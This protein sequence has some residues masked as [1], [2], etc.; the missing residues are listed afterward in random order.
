MENVN[1]CGAKEINVN[2]ESLR[3][4]LKTQLETAHDF[5]MQD[6]RIPIYVDEEG[7]CTSGSWLSQGSYQPNAEELPKVVEPWTMSDRE[8]HGEFVAGDL[9][10]GQEGYNQNDIDYEIGEIIEWYIDNVIR[11]EERHLPNKVYVLS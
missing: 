2:E 6:C 1:E 5:N 4:V 11:E 8:Y 3:G 9:E 10:E 7:N